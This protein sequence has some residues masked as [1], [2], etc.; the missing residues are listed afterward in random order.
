MKM[1]S[2]FFHS[3]AAIR[4]HPLRL[5]SFGVLACILWVS[6]PCHGQ[7]SPLGPLSEPSE[8]NPLLTSTVQ[9]GTTFLFDLERKFAAAVARGGGPALASFFYNGGMTLA[10][11]QA[12]VIGQQSIADHAG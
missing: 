4:H 11:R 9:P 1:D 5:V 2:G 8:S 12:P 3:V 10:N 7:E 6:V